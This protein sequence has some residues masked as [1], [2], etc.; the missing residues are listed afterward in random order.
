VYVYDA[1]N[2]FGED[3]ERQAADSIDRIR[4]ESGVV[5]V[6]F[7][8]EK[9]ES[10][11]PAL[12]AKDAADLMAQWSSAVPG[13]GNGLLVLFDVDA[14][15]CHGQV[16]LFAGPSLRTRMPASQRQSIYQDDMLPLLR[17]C[18][19]GGGLNAALDATA[20]ALET[21]TGV[22]GT[23]APGGGVAPPSESA[24]NVLPVDPSAGA[25]GDGGIPG[26]IVLPEL[27]P[28]GANGVPVDEPPDGD[29]PGVDPFAAGSP[30]A[31]GGIG[32]VF[33]VGILLMVAIVTI[34]AV[35]GASGR[36]GAPSSSALG[37]SQL[38][39]SINPWTGRP[40]MPWDGPWPG[41]PPHSDSSIGLGGP[42]SDPGGFGSSDSAGGAGS[43]GASGGAGS[44]GG[45]F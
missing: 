2:V 11:T 8:Q 25:S 19:L 4:T 12:A 42:P 21:D 27:E 41:V 14:S 22:G 43:G 33:V 23:E 17:S 39:Q 7:A 20:L 36:G 38:G 16:Q 1:P 10:N 18:D 24:P 45:G 34:G 9:P 15:H 40:W 31:M 13:F 32:V 37:P 3:A 5:V 28:P 35:T 30:F 29:L 26:G 44:A 6:A